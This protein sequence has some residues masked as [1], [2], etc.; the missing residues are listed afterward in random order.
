MSGNGS[1]DDAAMSGV[2]V[3]RKRLPVAST[4][5]K[6]LK[7]RLP[8]AQTETGVPAKETCDGEQWFRAGRQETSKR[9]EVDRRY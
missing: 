1:S 8:V 2:I 3:L 5:R 9:P 6:I 7:W 4:P